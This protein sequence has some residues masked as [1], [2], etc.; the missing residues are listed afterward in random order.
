MSLANLKA[1]P[2]KA[3]TNESLNAGGDILEK[4]QLNYDAWRDLLQTICGYYPAGIEPNAFTGW[5]RPV[6]VHGFKAVAAGCNAGRVERDYRDVRLDGADHYFVLFPVR[7][8]SVLTQNDQAV[9]LDVGDVVLVDASRPA[10][11]LADIHGSEQWRNVALNLPRRDLVAHL[12]FEPQ[13]GLVRHGGTS[14]GRLLLEVIRSANEDA[15]SKSSP[16]DRYMRFVVYD[17]IGALFAPS[18]PR[19]VSRHADKLFA[20]IRGAINDGFADPDFGPPE[21]AA[22]TGLSLRY[23]QKLFTQRGSTCSEIIYSRRLE[24]AA[25]LLHRRD[26]RGTPQPLSEIAYACGFRDYTHFARKFRCRFGHP[27]GAHSAKND[28][29]R[30]ETVRPSANEDALSAREPESSLI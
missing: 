1:T 11:F 5:V 8:G 6:D 19:S 24:H 18:D 27:P 23:V 14:A 26:S 2:N 7:G 21:V 12:G 29:P 3:D 30:D 20:R 22:K 13:S 15:A 25:R 16:T 28:Q 4:P 9:R 10:K 17:L